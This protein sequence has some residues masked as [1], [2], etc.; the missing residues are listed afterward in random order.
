MRKRW[1]FAGNDSE[2]NVLGIVGRTANKNL[3]VGK[4]YSPE[5]MADAVADLV[6]QL[7]ALCAEDLKNDFLLESRK[8]VELGG[9]SGD[10]S[11]SVGMLHTGRVLL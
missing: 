4:L 6:V 1:R 11:L 5:Q 8:H 3:K 7:Y 2:R 10:G 9:E